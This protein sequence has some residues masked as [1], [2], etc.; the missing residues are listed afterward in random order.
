MSVA[1]RWSVGSVLV[2]VVACAAMLTACDS[3]APA[4]RS[5]SPVPSVSS[6]GRTT[7]AAAVVATIET[8]SQPCASVEGGG[9]MWVTN[10]GAD[11]VMKVD[12]ATN[13]VVATFD[14]GTRP[15]GVVFAG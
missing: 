4:G 13:Q 9:F 2:V 1:P 6:P 11:T 7:P 12:P 14:T 3:G 15:C 8:D 5:S 10:Y